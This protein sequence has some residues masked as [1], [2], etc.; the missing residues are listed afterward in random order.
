MARALER[1]EH[2]PALN[3]HPLSLGA[4]L[5]CHAHVS[6]VRQSQASCKSRYC[7]NLR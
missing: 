1:I 3:R 6:T 7:D 2:E 5:V 4:D